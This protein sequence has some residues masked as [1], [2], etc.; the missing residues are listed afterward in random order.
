MTSNSIPTRQTDVFNGSSNTLSYYTKNQSN[1]RFYAKNAPILNTTGDIS[2]SNLYLSG[3]I[4]DHGSTT[5]GVKRASSMI[6]DTT[7]SVG[8]NLTVADTITTGNLQTSWRKYW[9]IKSTTAVSSWYKLVSFGINTFSSKGSVRVKGSIVIGPG[10]NL[11]GTCDFNFTFTPIPSTNTV[12]TCGYCCMNNTTS[13]QTTVLNATNGEFS[14]TTTFVSGSNYTFDLYYYNISPSGSGNS[15]SFTVERAEDYYGGSDQNLTFYSPSNIPVTISPANNTYILQNLYLNGGFN[16]LNKDLILGG[17]ITS[18]AIT[19]GTLTTTGP[20]TLN[21]IFVANLGLSATGA[22]VNINNTGANATSIA[23]GT[24]TLQLGNYTG[25]TILNGSTRGQSDNSFFALDTNAAPRMALI[26]KQG[27]AYSQFC[28]DNVST[29]KFEWAKLNNTITNSNISTGTATPLLTLDNAGILTTTNDLVVNGNLSNTGSITTATS[30][31]L[32][33]T[34]GNTLSTQNYAGTNAFIGNTNINNTGAANSNIG[35]GGGTV[36]IG[37]HATITG[38]TNINANGPSITNIGN[39]TGPVNIG[40]STGGTNI[41]GTITGT[42]KF[43]LPGFISDYSS[44]IG[45]ASVV[46]IPLYDFSGKGSGSWI[47]T[48][49]FLN[50]ISDTEVYTYLGHTDTNSIFIGSTALLSSGS[51]R[52]IGVSGSTFSINYGFN[53]AAITFYTS[54][55]KISM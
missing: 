53:S 50:S 21:N 40:N 32:T 18:T 46:A 36:T 26:K 20:T 10:N 42:G 25:N 41:T 7:M 1:Q 2:C 27:V 47:M 55:N 39:G 34:I 51:G 23:T 16:L 49:K 45:L 29:S 33:S 44:R 52:I 17:N 22:G 37:G 43:S 13:I 30:G 48:V 8:T 14:Y 19:T 54:I 38:T 12:N 35:K 3:S 9:E 31:A 5:V 28:I 15:A 4:S 6:S 24:G 11:N